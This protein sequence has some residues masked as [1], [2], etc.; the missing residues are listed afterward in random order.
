MHK[1]GTMQE[2]GIQ[3][4][5]GGNKQRVNYFDVLH[6]SRAAAGANGPNAGGLAAAGSLN[7]LKR[8]PAKSPTLKD[9]SLLN[10]S[11]FFVINY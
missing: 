5:V 1:R 10:R 4:A 2:D 3:M 11:K 7:P 8:P 9:Q 6:D